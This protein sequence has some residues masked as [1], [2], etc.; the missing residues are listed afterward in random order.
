MENIYVSF[1][2]SNDITVAEYGAIG[3]AYMCTGV[4]RDISNLV[5]ILGMLTSNHIM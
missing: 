4:R 2:Y 1:L 3:V 5:S